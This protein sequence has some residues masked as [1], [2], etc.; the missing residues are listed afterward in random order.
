MRFTVVACLLGLLAGCASAPEKEIAA[1]EE[2]ALPGPS[3]IGSDETFPLPEACETLPYREFVGMPVDGTDW[4]SGPDLRIFGI[5]DIITQDYRPERT[6][7]VY[8][9]AG[10]LMRVYCG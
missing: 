1:P 7:V 5:N 10:V 4:A 2:R 9:E 3:E 8:D 6:N